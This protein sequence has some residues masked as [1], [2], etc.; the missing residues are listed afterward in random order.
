MA[1]RKNILYMLDDER[2]AF[3]EALIRLKGKIVNTGDPVADQYSVYDQFTSLHWAVFS[4]RKSPN[5]TPFNAGHGGPSFLSW[6]RE[7]LR[8]FEAALQAEV[9]GVMLPYWDWSPNVFTNALMGPDG[10]PNGSGGGDVE[11]GWFAYDRPGTPSTAN[12]AIPLPAWWPSSV[13][14]WRI[15][16]DLSEGWGTVLQRFMATPGADTLP[17][18]SDVNALLQITAPDPTNATQRATAAGNFR[19]ALEVGSLALGVTASHNEVHRFI[20]GHM[21]SQPS[22]NDPIFWLH[23]CNIDRLWAMWQLDGHAGPDWFPV[24]NVDGWRLTDAMWPWIGNVAY[25]VLTAVPQYYIPSFAAEPPVLNQDVLDHHVLGYAYDTEPILGIALDRSGSMTGPSTDPFNMNG[26]TTKWE[27]AKIGVSNL[28]AD[29]EAAYAAREAYVIGG[30]QTFTTTG[31]SNDVSPVVPAKAYGLVRSGANPPAYAAA[32]VN[33]ALTGLNPAGGTPLAAALNE[34]YA[35]VVR[36][37]ANALPADD[38]RYLSILTDGKETAMPW[39]NTIGAGQ[40]ADTYIFGLGFGSGTGWDGVDY[41]M[42][43]TIVSKGKTPPPA[44][45][46]TQVYQGETMGAIDK[47]YSNTVARAIGYTPVVDPRFELYPGEEIHLPFW[48]TSAEDGFFITVLRGDADVT[49]WHV[50]LEAPDGKKYHASPGA[51]Y[52]ITIQRRDRRDTIFLRRARAGDV[53]WIGRWFLHLSYCCDDPAHGHELGQGHNHAH[54]HDHGDADHGHAAHSRGGMLMHSLFDLMLPVSAPPVV[55]PVFSQFNLAANKRVSARLLKQHI[56]TIGAPVV[57]P[58]EHGVLPASSPVVVNIYAKTSLRIGFRFAE[59][60]RWAGDRLLAA[61]EFADPDGGIFTRLKARAR[62]VAPRISMAAAFLDHD[63]IPV[64]DRKK[65]I[66]R[67]G[68]R[69]RFDE[70]AFLA[71][72]ERKKPGVFTPRDE[73]VAMQPDGARFIARVDATEPPGAYYVG[74]YIEGFLVR[75]GREPE[76]FTRSLSMT[77]SLGVRIDRRASRV[78]AKADGKTLEF[79]ITPRDRFGNIVSPTSFVTPTIEIGGRELEVQHED[80]LDGSHR[81]TVK[82]PAQRERLRRAVLRVA[83][84]TLPLEVEM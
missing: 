76:H 13:L 23:H 10:G 61:V 20:D 32:D 35:D 4:V 56:S 5:G 84:Q 37:P 69:D 8:R 55:G 83:G 45:G 42:I 15:R 25:D 53:Q 33:A 26:P 27:L 75:P 16:D 44:L 36:P 81:L 72:Y 2:A 30:V 57:E 70:L 6:H 65:F 47:F 31:G 58:D 40:F 68:D 14:G 17:V 39:L 7:L 29:C 73:L 19:T 38:V 9:P 67:S 79:V 60:A 59:P 62:L 51:P 50:M 34:T 71:E 11:T 74:A 18:Q 82:L 54:D 3:F 64:K 28:L 78:V 22:P 46:L 21:I 12:A 63:T 43:Q 77:A 48:A 52:H 80:L 49:K 24:S 41:A 66:R 1:T